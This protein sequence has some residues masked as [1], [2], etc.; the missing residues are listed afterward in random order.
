MKKATFY[1]CLFLIVFT[2]KISAQELVLDKNI[3]TI[4]RQILKEHN[5]PGLNFSIIYKDGNQQDYSVGLS[6]VENKIPLNINHTLFSGSIGKTYAAA[7]VMKLVD[8]N[9]IDLKQKLLHYF[10]NTDWLKKLPNANNISIEMLLQHTSGL[11]RYVLKPEIWDELSNNPDKV[12]TYHDRLSVIFNEAAVHEAGKDWEYSDTNYI[13]LGML[14]EEVTGENYYDLIDSIILKPYNLKNTH[15]SLRRDIPNLSVA[16]SQLPP[17]FHMPNIVVV[18]GKYVFNPQV[19]W[20]GGG[21][22]CTTS[23]LA[24]WAKIYYEGKLFSNGALKQITTTNSNSLKEKRS[25][26]YG[27]GSFIY[28]TKHGTAF[29][30][31]GFMPGFNS[32]FIYYKDLEV[33]AAIQFN[34][35]YASSKINMNNLLHDLISILIK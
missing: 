29:G 2:N 13:L 30:H 35:D 15:V 31:T 1:L 10:P 11:P 7:L 27:M 28:N 25:D 5:L 19:E 9:K 21:F 20:T 26:P 23:D 8:E 24:K 14:I 16:Y 32:I 17:E 6:D 3:D 34:S 33:A 18:D 22:A 12:W 4:V